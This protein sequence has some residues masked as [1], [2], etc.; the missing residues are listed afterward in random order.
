VSRWFW[1]VLDEMTNAERA[2]LL[3][4]VTG[5][6]RVPVGG[7]AALQG[8]DGHKCPFTLKVVR[9]KY[10]FF[11]EA[12]TCFNALYLPDYTDKEDMRRHLLALVKTDVTGFTLM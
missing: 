12:H 2:R 4:F 5:T 7:L 9:R 3:Q 10:P 11:P 6:S 1:G 8:H